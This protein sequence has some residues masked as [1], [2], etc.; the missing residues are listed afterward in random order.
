MGPQLAFPLQRL[1]VTFFLVLRL[2]LLKATTF[3]LPNSFRGEF[4]E[5]K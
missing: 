1:F 2:T 4:Y 5:Y 3:V